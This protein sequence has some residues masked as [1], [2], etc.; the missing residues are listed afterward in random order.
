[1]GEQPGRGPFLNARM[2]TEPAQP[3][4]DRRIPLKCAAERA[5][6]HVTTLKR[7]AL[8]GELRGVV[9]R[10]ARWFVSERALDVWMRGEPVEATS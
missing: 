6:C 8:R 5:A 2:H 9:K 3:I 10:G 7:A 4:V 1:M